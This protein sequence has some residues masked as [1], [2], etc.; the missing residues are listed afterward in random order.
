MRVNDGRKFGLSRHVS[1]TILIVTASVSQA[2]TPTPDRSA[3]AQA[4]PNLQSKTVEAGRVGLPSGTATITAA[5][6]IAAVTTAPAFAEYCQVLGTIA[7][8]TA[9]ADPIRFQINLPTTWNG[10]AVMIGGGGFNGTLT[11]AAAPLR[12]AASGQPQPI[13]QGFATFGTDS[14]HD[15]SSYVNTDPA[16]FALNDEMFLNFAHQAYKKVRDVA[17]EVMLAY[18]L[19]KPTKQYFYGGSEG[20]REG[21]T[22]AQRY[23]DDFDG[24]VSV[25][26]VIYWT[27]LFNGFVNYTLPQFNGGALNAAKINLLARTIN[28]ACDGLD[29]IADG[30]VSNYLACPAK[31]DLQSLRCAAGADTGDTCLSDAQ[32]TTLKAAYDPTVMPFA[33]ANGLTTYPGR[34]YG[35]EIQLGGEGV[36]R[37]I[38]N[39]TMPSP[40]PT[41]ND[42]R[43]VIYGSSYVRYVIA[44]DANFDIRTYNP[45]KFQQ[46]IQDVSALMDSSNPDLSA[47]LKRGGKLI[48]K[49]NTGDW[50]Q[51]PLAGIQY[52]QNVV[53]RMGQS[54]VDTFLRL[55][56][57]SASSHAGGAASLT[58]GTEVPTHHD[59][60]TTLDA[61]ASTDTPPPDA[62]IQVRNDKTTPFAKRA[63]RPMCR[64]PSY[65]HYAGGDPLQATSYRCEV[66]AP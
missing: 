35:G 59:L 50:A 61:W 26:P 56:V 11:D 43:G 65:P 25:V 62:L 57:S 55:Y 36:A 48:I 29:G 60:L 5:K 45:S 3:L 53:A 54:D 46:R 33:L 51:S 39:G 31:I 4:C 7:P 47:F 49:E 52:Y 12:D 2:A 34:L 21:L 9:G 63:A 8:L 38:S 22:M 20:G 64:Y 40:L 18:Y 37:W 16:K 32:L 42:G 19:S 30:V 24:I 14:G 27:G 28:S 44:R 41:A 6:L 10:K 23:P 58:T 17:Q 15:A 13:T 1:A 66:S